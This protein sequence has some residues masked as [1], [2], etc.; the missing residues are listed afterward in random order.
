MESLAAGGDAVARA[1]DGRVVF[2]DG[3]APGDLVEVALIEQK[4]RF[5]RGRVIEVI[6]AGAA[7]VVPP[8][9]VA[10]RCGGCPWQ[11]VSAEGQRAAKQAIVERALGRL[12]SVRPII[13]A[14]VALGYRL[15]ATLHANGGRLGFLARRSHELVEHARCMAL[16]P[17]LDEALALA[18][19]HED[20]ALARALGEEGALRGTVTPSGEVQ[21]A[22]EPGRGASLDALARIAAALLGRA[23][24]AGVLVDRAAVGAALVDAGAPSAAHWVSAAGFRQANHAQNDRLRALVCAALDASGRTV[25]E[26]YAG[27]GNFTRDLAGARKLVAVEEDACAI[28]R[29]Q[30]SLPG[31]SAARAKVEDELAR[32]VRAGERWD[33][34]LLDPPR[35]GAKDAMA[36]IAGLEPTRVVYVSCDPATLARDA[37][38]LAGAGYTLVEAQ[39]I[40][41]MPQTDHTEVVLLAVRREA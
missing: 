18:R 27:D 23:N 3:A 29:L 37:R 25:L 2:I 24:I 15:R 12:V 5:A 7:R 10:D 33:R 38:T 16:E 8:C 9:P 35:T 1:P 21:L 26:L 34:V 36:A 40:D 41:L 19:A 39:P 6:E 4:A 28:A 11:M 32:R 20:G 14:P 17:S 31:V 13:A 30:R 22:L